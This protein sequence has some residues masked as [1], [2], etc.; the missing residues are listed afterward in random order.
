MCVCVE[1]RGPE[2]GLKEIHGQLLGPSTPGNSIVKTDE[3][4]VVVVVVVDGGGGGP[5]VIFFSLRGGTADQD[6][7]RGVRPLVF[8]KLK[9]LRTLI[10]E[11]ALRRTR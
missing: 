9:V 5:V 11:L 8:Q 4:G 1:V 6:K 3:G 7:M 10:D 2:A